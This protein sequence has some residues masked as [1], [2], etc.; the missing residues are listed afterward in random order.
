MHHSETAD[1]QAGGQTLTGSCS[2]PSS[3][4]MLESPREEI[5]FELLL[6]P[7]EVGLCSLNITRWDCTQLAPAQPCKEE[8]PASQQW[9]LHTHRPVSS[10]KQ[11]E[12]PGGKGAWIPPR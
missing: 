11:A 5:S 7:W 8:A 9:E 10:S 1:Q 2:L 12:P 3:Q 6:Q 4:K